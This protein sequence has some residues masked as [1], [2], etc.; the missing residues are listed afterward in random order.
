MGVLSKRFRLLLISMHGLGMYAPLSCHAPPEPFRPVL[1]RHNRMKCDPVPG[2][3]ARHWP[4]RQHVHRRA[5]RVKRWLM[6][7]CERSWSGLWNTEPSRL[8][9][10]GGRKRSRGEIVLE[11]LDHADAEAAAEVLGGLDGTSYRS[12]NMMIADTEKAFWLRNEARDD[13]EIDIFEIPEE[14]SGFH[15][16]DVNDP[17]SACRRALSRFRVAQIP[18]PDNGDWAA[19]ETLLADRT[20]AKSDDYAPPSISDNGAGFA[21]LSSSPLIAL[22]AD[23]GCHPSGVSCS[24]ATR[25][26]PT[27]H[28]VDL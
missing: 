23:P 20:R 11:A 14:V 10:T 1:I 21:T 16:H 26:S 3:P 4:D 5:G 7:W 25:Q 13:G 24:R 28:S 17:V 19:W 18:N 12:F 22:P 2:A 9:R 15:G 8:A 27:L 6:A